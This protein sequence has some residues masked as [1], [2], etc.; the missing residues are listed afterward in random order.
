MGPLILQTINS[1]YLVAPTMQ[2]PFSS[3]RLCITPA[4]LYVP[5][6]PLTYLA[7]VS[8]HL[9][10]CGNWDSSIYHT[11]SHGQHR[12]VGGRLS[13]SQTGSVEQTKQ[14]TLHLCKWGRRACHSPCRHSH[15]ALQKCTTLQQSR[16]TSHSGKNLKSQRASSLRVSD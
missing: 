3:D 2:Y 16:C 12:G 15:R 8:N 6:S 10:G 14:V 11:H 13:F 5:T 4:E 9:S 7:H 1:T